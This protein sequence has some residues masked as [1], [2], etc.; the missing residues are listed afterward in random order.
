MRRK[1]FLLFVTVIVVAYFMGPHPTTPNFTKKL[2]VVP[3]DPFALEN[4]V[5]EKE[6]AHKLKP[7]NEARI[8]WNDSTR[9]KT[10]YAIVYLPGFTASQA[11]GAPVHK[12][13]ARKF[14]CNLYLSRLAEHGIDTTDALVNLTAENYWE[15]AQ[16]A[17]P[18]GKQIGNKV[19]LMGTSTGG[20]F[21]IILAAKFTEVSAILM[22]SPN[23][24]INDPFAFLLNNPWGLQIAHAVLRSDYIS[25]R[26]QRNIYKQYW[27]TPYRVE[28]AVQLE[29]LLERSMTEETFKKVNQPALSLYYY[30]DEVHQDS[31]VKVSAIKKMMEQLGTPDSLKRSI[32]IPNA[33]SHVIG[34]YLKSKDVGAVEQEIEK[35]MIEIIGLKPVH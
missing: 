8:I 3:S 20:T 33:D 11:E 31:V 14:G 4:Y 19:I 7:D 22:L 15:S 17:L 29:E 23:I 13:I 35:F 26:D 27:S 28:A 16:E 21:A 5:K 2:P 34:S 6:S 30:K 32:A 25:S 1:W 10:D 9:K 24:A 18:I 12:N